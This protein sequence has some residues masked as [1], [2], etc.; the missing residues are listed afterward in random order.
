MHDRLSNVHRIKG[1]LDNTA[2]VGL[3]RA[4]GVA[5][6]HTRMCVSCILYKPKHAKEDGDGDGARCTNID[7]SH[8]NVKVASFDG[9]RLGQPRHGVL[10]ARV[11]R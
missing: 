3:E 1:R 10:R 11:R 8:G 4:E 7:L 2:S 6:C 5:G 9:A